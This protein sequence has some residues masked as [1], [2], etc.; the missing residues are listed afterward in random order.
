MF[1]CQLS[2]QINDDMELAMVMDTHAKSVNISK[3]TSSCLK[4]IST[5][6]LE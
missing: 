2:F 4:N 1:S 5:N 3:S 6:K